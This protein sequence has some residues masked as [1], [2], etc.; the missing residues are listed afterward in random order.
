MGV[1]GGSGV[2]FTPGVRIIGGTAGGRLLATP[3]GMTV[4]PTPD[5]VRQAVFNSLGTSVEGADVLDIFS[6]TGALGLEFLSRGAR[7]VLSVELS[8]KHARFIRDN[9]QTLGL[10]AEAHELRVQDAFAAVRQLAVT[11]RR[12][13]FIVADPPFGPKNTAKRSESASQQLL[14]MPE[15]RGLLREGGRLVLGHARRDKVSVGPPWK[16][17]RVLEHGDSVFRMLGM[18]GAEVAP[19]PET[20]AEPEASSGTV[21]G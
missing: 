6:G 3:K 7:S 8:S 16:E 9:R 15:V 10:P 13:D 11:D 4:R 20:S 18:V 12:F 19:S 5:L 1:G 17:F 14:D 21:D 2:A